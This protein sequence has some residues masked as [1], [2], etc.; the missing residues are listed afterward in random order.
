MVGLVQRSL[1]VNPQSPVA[2][3][4]AD[5]QQEQAQENNT[6]D[7]G[8]QP[9]DCPVHVSGGVVENCAGLRAAKRGKEGALS[10][11]VGWWVQV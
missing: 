11:W 9:A 5:G 3:H 4:S 10:L 7:R 2:A 6:G 8:Q 1:K